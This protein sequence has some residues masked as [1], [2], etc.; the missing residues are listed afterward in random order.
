MLNRRPLLRTKAVIDPTG[1]MTIEPWWLPKRLNSGL[2]GLCIS[3][4]GLECFGGDSSWGSPLPLDQI[5][6]ARASHGV[7]AT[8]VVIERRSAGASANSSTTASTLR[9]TGFSPVR[10]ARF[11]AAVSSLSSG[12]RLS[13]LSGAIDTALANWNHPL[14][15][16]QFMTVPLHQEWR[17]TYSHLCTETQE[18]LNRNPPESDVRERGTQLVEMWCAGEAARSSRNARW[19]AG[20]RTQHADLFA[21]SMGYPLNEDQINAILH[22]EH[23]SLVVAG[24]GTGKTTT[25]VA[26]TKWIIDQGL[27]GSDQIRILAFNKKAAREIAARLASRTDAES[28]ASTFHS[29]GLSLVAQGRGRKP[30][31]TRLLEDQRHLQRFIR[32][33]LDAALRSPTDFEKVAEFLT[34]FRY[35]EANPVPA[36][37]SHEEFRFAEQHEIRTLTGVKVKSRSEAAIANWLTLNGINWEYEPK[38]PLDTATIR[39]GQ[40]HPD[41]FLPEYALYIEHWSCNSDG[42]FPPAWSDAEKRDYL[43]GMTWKRA[44]HARSG[45]RLVESYSSR[46]IWRDVVKVLERELRQ[47]QVTPKPLSDEARRALIVEDS[48]IGPVVI[49]LQRFLALFRESGMSFSDLYIEAEKR[50]D[51]RFKAFVDMFEGM[52]ARYVAHLRDEGTVDFSD[53]IRDAA[54]LLREGKAQLPIDYLIVDEFQDIS[55][56]R[57]EL[58]KAILAGNERCRLV[59]VGDD[60]Q[61]IYRFAGSDIRVMLDFQKE[62][63]AATRSDLQH[64][65]RFGN[66]LV[67]AT[68]RFIERNPRQLRKKLVAARKDVQPAI[69]I[70]SMTFVPP[71]PARSS[72]SAW[73]KET[74]SVVRDVAGDLNYLP[75]GE[76]YSIGEQS[77]AAA[78]ERL[79]LQIAVERDKASVLVLGRYNFLLREIEGQI[80]TPSN[81]SL[82]FSTVHR[83]KGLEADFVVILAVVTD[84]FGFPSEIEDDPILD[85]VLPSEADYP[86]AEERRLF[87]VALTRARSKAFIITRDATRSAFVEELEKADYVGLV[88][89][90][91]KSGR[92]VNCPECGGGT[93]ILREGKHGTYFR[94]AHDRCRGKAQR[95]PKCGRGGLIREQAKHVCLFCSYAAENCPNCKRGYLKH[96]PSGVSRD[97]GR[98]FEAFDACSTN[99]RQPQYSCYTRKCACS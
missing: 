82:S 91:G 32:S 46:L 56:G 55:R 72:R 48:L 64:T 1:A 7:I 52:H 30:R 24:A 83:A 31:L 33:C 39:Y 35:P 54:S 76:S 36:S 53:M 58:I 70:V 49:L 65:Q 63:G 81:V 25:V 44:L 26:K 68:S 95:C 94:C 59:A 51:E 88:T 93:L 45:T 22:D 87:Y 13:E 78:L 29:L 69:E 57:A 98:H 27:A 47:L 10:A 79:L 99:R 12:A 80:E 9:F 71:A 2:H 34:F 16:D 40:Y 4:R 20:Q 18:L 19:M 38:Y 73:R 92:A 89:G 60:W 42:V 3:G 23:R 90:S 84:P 61:S 28:I 17:L 41:F 43:D 14:D 6:A 62:F 50:R 97:R 37:G 85:L 77:T 21:H 75:M 5:A 66:K 86:N 15:K 74:T 8:A 67:E 96:I 11:A